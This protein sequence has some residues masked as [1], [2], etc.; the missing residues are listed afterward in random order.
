MSRKSLSAIWRN[1]QKKS[2]AVRKGT[3][4]PA[5]TIMLLKVWFKQPEA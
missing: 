4:A 2:C 1:S 5:A 3:P